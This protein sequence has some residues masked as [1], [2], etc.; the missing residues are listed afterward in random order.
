LVYITQFPQRKELAKTNPLKPAKKTSCTCRKRIRFAPFAAA[1]KIEAKAKGK[2]GVDQH[3]NIP[4]LC[5]LVLQRSKSG[6]V[7]RGKQKKL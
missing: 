1:L 7:R 6:N 5:I 4:F 2:A 3:S